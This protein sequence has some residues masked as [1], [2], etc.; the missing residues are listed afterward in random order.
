MSR[1]SK[2][3]GRRHIRWKH[4]GSV[5]IYIKE[6]NKNTRDIYSL[7]SNWNRMEHIVVKVGEL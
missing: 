6:R 1:K 3:I 4:E 5:Y 2:G 7:L